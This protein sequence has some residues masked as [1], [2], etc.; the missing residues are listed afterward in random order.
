MR[1][2]HNRTKPNEPTY[3]W[4]EY[5][6]HIAGLPYETI[7]FV[8]VWC[9][10]IFTFHR[11]TCEWHLAWHTQH[12][13]E[14]RTIVFS[15]VFPFL[16][17]FLSLFAIHRYTQAKLYGARQYNTPVSTMRDECIYDGMECKWERDQRIVAKIV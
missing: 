16:S 3:E 2:T 5:I 13:T 11:Q 12:T 17:S 4:L 1:R 6:R 14:Q 15:V 10:C 7:I 9:E 8:S